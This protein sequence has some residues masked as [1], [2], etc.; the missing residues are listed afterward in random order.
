MENLERVVPA[1]HVTTA[2]YL[3]LLRILGDKQRLTHETVLL[4]T[5]AQSL[6]GHWEMVP[7]C[8]SQVKFQMSPGHGQRGND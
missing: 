5:S 7:I 1:L 4:T 2:G 8:T 3:I 6:Q